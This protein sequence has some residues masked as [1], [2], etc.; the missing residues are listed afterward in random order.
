MRLFSE[1]MSQA[2]KIIILIKVD[3]IGKC[4]QTSNKDSTL[5]QDTKQTLSPSAST[6]APHKPQKH[7]ILTSTS[8][9][10]KEK[11]LYSRCT[12]RD[13][14]VIMYVLIL[15]NYNAAYK[16]FLLWKA[17]GYRQPWQNPEETLGNLTEFSIM[18]FTFSFYPKCLPKQ[19][20]KWDICWHTWGVKAKICIIRMSSKDIL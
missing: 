2:G 20:H 10:P 11:M 16:V 6:K 17:L 12:V 19:R 15:S 18:S 1:D 13:G 4:A 7:Q 14:F 5:L 3:V 9:W 8:R